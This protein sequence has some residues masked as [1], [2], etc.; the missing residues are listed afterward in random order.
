[1]PAG[2]HSK[3][4]VVWICPSSYKARRMSTVDSSR[5]L[6][7]SRRSR[8]QQDTQPC[9]Q[10]RDR[11]LAGPE[12]GLTASR[13]LCPAVPPLPSR[14]GGPRQLAA[15]TT[16]GANVGYK[17]HSVTKTDGMS[18]LTASRALFPAG[19]PLP[20]RAGSPQWSL[21]AAKTFL[22]CP[23][24][25]KACSGGFQQLLPMH[26]VGRVSHVS[27]W[28]ATCSRCA[29]CTSRNSRPPRPELKAQARS[30]QL[31][32]CTRQATTCII[33]DRVVEAAFEAVCGVADAPAKAEALLTMSV[34][35]HTGSRSKGRGAPVVKDR[36]LPPGSQVFQQ[37]GAPAERL[38]V[39]RGAPHAA[40][41]LRCSLTRSSLSP[42]GL[43]S[44]R[45]AALRRQCL[46]CSFRRTPVHGASQHSHLRRR[47]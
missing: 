8:R 47:V 38:S 32:T 21:H 45:A 37:V 26:S 29:A 19:P 3:S 6:T 16:A 11:W 22:R 2:P 39:S 4:G 10:H 42:P 36:E 12:R 17:L 18:E 30:T 41:A 7:S 43:Q 23:G 24:E 25:C 1:M 34:L 15:H 35:A 31:G 27:M 9:Q 28:L 14:A 40:A 5:L 44:A 13:A 33:C 46:S 20:A